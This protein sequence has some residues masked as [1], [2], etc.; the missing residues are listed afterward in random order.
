MDAVNQVLTDSNEVELTSSNFSSAVGVQG[1]AKNGVNRAYLEICA[2][3]VQWPFLRATESN[4]ND[5]Y[6]GMI[7]KETTAGTKWYLL[8]TGSTTV[9]GDYAKVDWDSFYLTEDGAT[10]QTAPYEHENLKFVTYQDWVDHLRESEMRDAA[11]TQ[12]YGLP[13]YVIESKDKRYFGLSPI[14]KEAYTIYYTAWVRPTKLS[15]HDDSL[16]LPDEYVHCLYS[17]A[18]YYMNKFKGDHTAAQ[19]DN[20][21]FEKQIREMHRALLGRQEKYMR[22]DRIG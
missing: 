13:R 8:K 21:A 9:A 3:D 6:D 20:A 19:M 12:Q 22:D 16:L 2:K 14:P 18:S 1:V 15:A 11:D 5:P 10:G 7:S 4:T 17:R